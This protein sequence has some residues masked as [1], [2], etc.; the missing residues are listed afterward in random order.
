MWLHYWSCQIIYC[1][2]FIMI[3]Y[4]ISQSI[5][6]SQMEIGIIRRNKLTG[7]MHL[8]RDLYIRKK[9]TK[10]STWLQTWLRFYI[11]AIKSQIPCF[12]ALVHILCWSFQLPWLIT[13]EAQLQKMEGG[14]FQFLRLKI[15]PMLLCCIEHVSITPN[16]MSTWWLMM[17]G[18]SSWELL[19]VTCFWEW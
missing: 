12:K 8:A 15:S 1:I 5:W 14:P 17:R 10:L 2:S 9:M 18:H 4:G 3:A 11:C 6:R 13:S 16:K 7:V 19:S